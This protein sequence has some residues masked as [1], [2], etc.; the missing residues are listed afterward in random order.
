MKTII[1]TPKGHKKVEKEVDGNTVISFEPIK[2]SIVP[3]SWEDF[4]MKCPKTLNEFYIT[5]ASTVIKMIATENKRNNTDRNHLSTKQRAKAMLAFIQL[6]R[7]RDYVNGDW[8]ADWREEL[9]GRENKFI[10]QY[11]NGNLLCGCE[12]LYSHPLHFKT[13]E[14]RD[15]FLTN[16]RDLIEEAKEFI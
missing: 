9:R 1:E 11:A 12:H 2:E 10:I 3:K 7:V 6:I 16:F 13:K 14:I 15:Q 8:E 4:C 5:S